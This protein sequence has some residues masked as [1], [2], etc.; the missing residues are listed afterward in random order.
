MAM[1]WWMAAAV[2]GAALLAAAPAARRSLI[3]RRGVAR[4]RAQLAWFDQERPP[5]ERY[6][7]SGAQIDDPGRRAAP[8]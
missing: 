4:A 7:G 1:Q 6:G 3:R 5:W 2:A 8:G